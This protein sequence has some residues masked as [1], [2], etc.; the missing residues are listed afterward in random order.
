MKLLK[1]AAHLLNNKLKVQVCD[2]TGD[3]IKVAAGTQKLLFS[4]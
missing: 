2:A 1:L 3:A 4:F